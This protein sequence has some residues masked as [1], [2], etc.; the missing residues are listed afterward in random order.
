MER[1]LLERERGMEKRRKKGGKDGEE[2]GRRK[3]GKKEGWKKERWIR[4]RK[5]RERKAAER[6]E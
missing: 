5:K 2:E 1:K 4:G 6:K 3:D